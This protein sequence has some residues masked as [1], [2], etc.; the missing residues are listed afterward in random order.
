MKDEVRFVV[1][2]AESTTCTVMECVPLATEVDA[3]GLAV[4]VL[5]PRKSKGAAVSTCLGSPTRCG[6]SSQ[7][8]TLET[9]ALGVVKM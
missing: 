1:T 6:S 3:H 7:N 5:P 9:P 2:L 8:D 4:V